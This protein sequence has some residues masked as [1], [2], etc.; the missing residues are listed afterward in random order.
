MMA[1]IHM[2]KDHIQS[3]KDIDMLEPYPLLT[4]KIDPSVKNIDDFEFKNFEV[5][6]YIRIKRFRWRCFF[7]IFLWVYL[8]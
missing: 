3:L 1:G 2:Y 6:N 5:E 8:L 7:S 4:F